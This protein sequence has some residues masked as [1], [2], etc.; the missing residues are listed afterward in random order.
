[1][2]SSSVLKYSCSR[3][4]MSRIPTCVWAQRNDR[5]FLTVQLADAKGVGINIDGGKVSIKAKAKDSTGQ[6]TDYAH[7]FNL[8]KPAASEGSTHKVTDR[9]IQI[10]IKKAEEGFWDRMTEEPSKLSKQ[11]LSCDWDRWRDEED[12]EAEQ[13]FGYGNLDGM[14]FGGAGG[15]S[16]DEDDVPLD[17]LDGDDQEEGAGAAASGA[18]AD[19]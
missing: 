6:A 3:Q 4:P 7:T 16:D 10:N 5:V 12:G 1:M 18:A 11:F 13:D 15:D 2:G 19:A 9:E 8:F 17:D 14:D